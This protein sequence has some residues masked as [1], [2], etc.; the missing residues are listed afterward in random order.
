MGVGLRGVHKESDQVAA[1]KLP[2]PEL[3]KDERWAS[4]FEGE[5]KTLAKL[6]HPNLVRLQA[7][8]R[9]DA[10]MWLAMDWMEG[11]SLS[12]KIGRGLGLGE[13]RLL[14]EQAVRGLGVLH[15][16]GIV[17]RDLKPSNLLVGA[18]GTLKLAD[19]GLA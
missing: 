13:V 19:F 7:S 11:E 9:E 16:K 8:G 12:G 2:H 4:R 1:I 14:M 3:V 15:G 6:V 17:H 10:M 5:I 18:D